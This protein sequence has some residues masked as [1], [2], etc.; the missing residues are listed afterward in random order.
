MNYGVPVWQ[1]EGRAQYCHAAPVQ[2]L[3][4]DGLARYGAASVPQSNTCNANWLRKTAYDRIIVRTW[5]K[6][7][8][9]IAE[10]HR[11]RNWCLSV[12]LSFQ[13]A[14]A[15]PTVIA[16]P[17]CCWHTVPLASTAA[18][19]L[20]TANHFGPDAEESGFRAK[21]RPGRIFR[22]CSRQC[23]WRHL[24]HHPRHPF[25]DTSPNRSR[26]RVADDLSEST[27]DSESE[28]P[29]AERS[30]KADGRSLWRRMA[31][32]GMGSCRAEHVPGWCRGHKA[33]LGRAKSESV[34]LVKSTT[35]TRQDVT[36]ALPRGE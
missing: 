20:Y 14:R 8:C 12:I 5:R 6:S 13:V 10:F 25:A 28:Q 9:N 27:D 24:C 11:S 3:I 4:L 30:H 21:H 33:Q 31:V 23:G 26:S 29:R 18:A 7:A 36:E 16:I 1:R 17:T 22:R 32:R 15:T 19:S 2:K 35:R 34:C